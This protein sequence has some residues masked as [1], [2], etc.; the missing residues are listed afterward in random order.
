MTNLEVFVHRSA[1]RGDEAAL[2]QA[3]EQA[4]AGY[5][6]QVTGGV[7]R[8]LRREAIPEQFECKIDL[9]VRW[10]GRLSVEEVD[11]DPGRAVDRAL[12]GLAQNLEAFALD[13]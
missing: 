3:V 11:Q 12:L 8:L 2:R 5:S 9:G 1:Q 7:V 4:L 10:W 6:D 13:G